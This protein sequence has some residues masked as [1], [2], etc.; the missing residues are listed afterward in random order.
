M[1]MEGFIFVYRKLMGSAVFTHLHLLKLWL[2]CMLKASYQEIE[3]LVGATPV[4]L[5]RGQFVWGRREAAE[6]LNRGMTCSEQRTDKTWENL[7]KRL[8]LEGMISREARRNFTIIT[9]TNYDRYQASREEGVPASLPSDFPDLGQ[10]A[11]AG[12]S[13]DEQAGNTGVV[14][15][16]KIGPAEISRDFAKGNE[17]DSKKITCNRSTNNNINNDNKRSSSGIPD[18]YKGSILDPYDMFQRAYPQPLTQLIAQTIDDWVQEF[19]GQ[20]EVVGYAIEL[21]GKNGA[22]SPRYYEQILRSW[23]RQGARSLMDAKR[24]N[25]EREEL[26]EAKFEERL[27]REEIARSTQRWPREK[28]PKVC[29]HNWLKD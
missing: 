18:K 7:L 25:R 29:M 17:G 3:L 9:V 26:Q 14:E 13:A 21:A 5:L 28:L 12:F 10:N 11:A 2:Y 15:R 16:A 19:N 24:L 20:S 22:G 8:E 23:Q 6:A 27:E 4:R 1:R